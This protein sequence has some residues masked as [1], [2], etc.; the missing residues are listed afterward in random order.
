MEHCLTLDKKLTLRDKR[1]RLAP[2]RHNC[3][4][5]VSNLAPTVTAAELAEV[6]RQYGA[7]HE[8]DTRVGQSWES[9]G[10]GELAATATGPGEKRR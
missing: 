1:L 5:E 7:L 8:E 9:M 6:F 10:V 4:L 2:T 3:R